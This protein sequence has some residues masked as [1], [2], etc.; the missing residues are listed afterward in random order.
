VDVLI[1]C[2][3]LY[4]VILTVSRSFIHEPLASSFSLFETSRFIFHPPPPPPQKLHIPHSLASRPAVADNIISLRF[5]HP[6]QFNIFHAKNDIHRLETDNTSSSIFSV[7]HLFKERNSTCYTWRFSRN[8][9][10]YSINIISVYIIA[11]HYGAARGVLTQYAGRA[12]HELV[13]SGSNSASNSLPVTIFVKIGYL[14]QLPKTCF[15]FNS[16][17]PCFNVSKLCIL[18]TECIFYDLECVNEY[19]R[20]LIGEKIYRPLTGRNYK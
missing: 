8:H 3:V 10:Q 17:K 16:L 12:Q 20:G 11:S 7:M 15:L 4:P 1:F 5:I 18:S 6:T 9:Q 14:E 2:A 13:A 19:R